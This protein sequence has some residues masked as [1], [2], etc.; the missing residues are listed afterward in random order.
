MPMTQHGWP[1][2][3]PLHGPALP[4]LWQVKAASSTSSDA[5]LA[6]LAGRIRAVIDTRLHVAGALLFRGVGA[7]GVTGPGGFSRL[8]AATGYTLDPY[9]VRT[10]AYPKGP[11]AT[12]PAMP[13]AMPT[14]MAT[15]QLAAPC[16][17]CS[18]V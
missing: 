14:A 10:T 7:A 16:S 9:K 15:R 13:T 4:Q 6:T 2:W 12:P 8:I 11:P 3:P 5:E 17:L 18:H 1:S